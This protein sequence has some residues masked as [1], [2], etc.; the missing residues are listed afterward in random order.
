MSQSRNSSQRIINLITIKRALQTERNKIYLFDKKAP[1]ALELAQTYLTS[2]HTQFGSDEFESS[3]SESKQQTRFADF[4]HQHNRMTILLRNIKRAADTLRTCKPTKNVTQIIKDLD[5]LHAATENLAKES[6][7]GKFQS[8]SHFIKEEMQPSA[9]EDESIVTVKKELIEMLPKIRSGEVDVSEAQEMLIAAREKWQQTEEKLTTSQE[10]VKKTFFTKVG[11]VTECLGKIPSQFML[12]E[13]IYKFA[14]ELD[15]KYIRFNQATDPLEG[16]ISQSGKDTAATLQPCAGK[17]AGYVIQWCESAVAGELHSWKNELALTETVEDYQKQQKEKNFLYNDT[18]QMA[19]PLHAAEKILEKIENGGVY[20]LS[21][22]M[23]SAENS[24]W[25]PRGHAFGIICSVNK[26]LLFD[27]N[28]GVFYLSVNKMK[29]FFPVLVAWYDSGFEMTLRHVGACNVNLKNL[30]MK[31]APTRQKYSLEQYV[32]AA[33]RHRLQIFD[34]KLNE[35]LETNEKRIGAELTSI[36]ALLSLAHYQEDN[37]YLDELLQDNEVVFNSYALNS[38]RREIASDA[39]EITATPLKKNLKETVINKINIHIYILRLEL[40]STVTRDKEL[41]AAKIAA[42]T[43]LINDINKASYCMTLKSIIKVWGRKKAGTVP[44]DLSSSTDVNHWE[45]ILINRKSEFIPSE[46][47]CFIKT[48]KRESEICPWYVSLMQAMVV[49]LLT[50]ILRSVAKAK[51][52]KQPMKP[53]SLTL[54]AAGAADVSHLLDLTS[55]ESVLLGLKVLKSGQIAE[56]FGREVPLTSQIE[57]AFAKL[58]IYSVSGL[59]NVLLN[60]FCLPAKSVQAIKS[61]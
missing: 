8:V 37:E 21:L 24:T 45:V 23:Y 34:F 7:A 4:E 19:Y 48:L 5:T 42:L 47:L 60:S 1:A 61:P 10:Q 14:E 2:A 59:W 41:A 6:A 58:D 57:R 29:E 44:A 13:I 28:Y 43:V 46:T 32:D 38:F 31:S 40:L 50:I 11:Q 27:P 20:K 51:L 17:C 25:V 26:V 49:R 9:D 53:A 30:E 55:A 16:F 12:R 22:G 33:I 18:D 54:F 36:K 56:L 52:A 15:V 3:V 35:A 39:K